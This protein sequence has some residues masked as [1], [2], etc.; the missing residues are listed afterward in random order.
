MIEK[1]GHAPLLTIKPSTCVPY[2]LFLKNLIGVSLLYNVVIFS[3]VQQS[4][5]VICIHISR[6]F[7]ISFPVTSPQNTEFLSYTVGSHQLSIL[8][9]VVFTCQSPNSTH[10]PFHPW[11]LYVCSL[12]R[13]TCSINYYFSLLQLPNYWVFLLHLQFTTDLYGLKILMIIKTEQNNFI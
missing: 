7:Q 2:L 13:E 11:Y 3:A 5:S 6:L 4:E 12:R 8:Y 9:T 1:Y 10:P